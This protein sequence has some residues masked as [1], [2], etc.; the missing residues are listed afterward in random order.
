MSNLNAPQFQDADKAREYLEALV[1]PNGPVC[2]H[3]GCVGD[4]YKLQGKTT[5]PGLFKCADCRE[6]FTVTVGTVFERSKIKLNVWLQAV[7][8]ICS[9]KKGISSLQLQ[10][11]LGVTY[12][13]AWFMSHRIRE[14]MTSE[15]GVF[16]SNGGAVEVDETY[17]GNKSKKAEGVRGWYHSMKVVSLVERDGQKKSYH[18]PTVNAATIRPILRKKIAAKAVL[19]TDDAKVY[20]P[21][22]KDFA[23]HQVVNHKSGEYARGD[24]TTNTVE[25]SFAILKRG[26][27]GTFHHVGEQHLQR[28][29]N[30]FDFRWNTRS[31]LGFDD[32]Q[33]TQIA[34]RG[35]SGKR[36][37]YRRIEGQQA[38]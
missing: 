30:E 31:K 38:A 26:L 14:A 22:G 1:W 36:L 17:W 35:I 34:L 4:H 28:Y 32:T 27:Y 15:G 6:Q 19:M 10:R 20:R 3:C 2:P 23:G 12:K 24:V 21:I 7:Y 29:A 18:V 25:S 33:R 9:S 8:L 16:G 5:R 13:T 37:T 11:M